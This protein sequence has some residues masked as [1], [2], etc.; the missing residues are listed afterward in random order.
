[1]ADP[2]FQELFDGS[3]GFLLRDT[4][5][6]V[7]F[8]GYAYA[9]VPG[10]ALMVR[11][12]NFGTGFSVKNAASYGVV[13]DPP[14]TPSP[15]GVTEFEAAFQWR[16]NSIMLSSTGSQL[17]IAV[18]GQDPIDGSVVS[19]CG[20]DCSMN[21]IPQ[22]TLYTQLDNSGVLNAPSLSDGVVYNIKLKAAGGQLSLTVDDVQIATLDLSSPLGEI[23]GLNLIVGGDGGIG[24]FTLSSP[25]N[26]PALPAWTGFQ[27]TY[28]V[29]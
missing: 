8:G 24:S 18:Y 28:E 29:F 23:C 27:N 21:A 5:P 15:T 16:T 11:D 22:W 26:P 6:E 12:G 7:G 25:G 14:P 4:R 1:M 3:R 2:F 19:Y 20:L 13:A 9:N 10:I 17:Q